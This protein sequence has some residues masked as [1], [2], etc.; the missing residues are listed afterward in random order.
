MCDLKQTSLFSILSCCH[1]VLLFVAHWKRHRFQ[2][3]WFSLKHRSSSKMNSVR[4][5]SV[6]SLCVCLVW[7]SQ[8]L[9]VNHIMFCKWKKNRE[10]Y[11][12]VGFYHISRVS[13]VGS[14][15][16]TLNSHWQ[17]TFR[18]SN[19]R[20]T[21]SQWE[22]LRFA[23]ITFH[24]SRLPFAQA[25]SQWLFNAIDNGIREENLMRS[26]IN[27]SIDLFIPICFSIF[28]FYYLRLCSQLACSFVLKSAHSRSLLAGTKNVTLHERERARKMVELSSVT[29]NGSTNSI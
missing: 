17:W 13:D 10:L 27:R 11:L 23:R 8:P 5:V 4:F 2:F 29:T 18:P 14:K 24:I 6:F 28:S 19:N 7:S 12:K 1:S 16:A 15:Y 20:T 25:F 26:P 3:Q 9:Q 22:H 21:E